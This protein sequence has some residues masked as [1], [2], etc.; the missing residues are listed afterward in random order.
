MS[1]LFGTDGVRGIA[2]KELTPELA[3]ALGRAGAFV[4]A[5]N[6]HKPKFVIGKDTRISG[7]LLESALIAGILSIGGEVIRA[8][9]IPTPAIAV[10]NRLLRAD[11]GVMISASHNPAE[12]NGIKFFDGQGF[13]LKDE[14]EDQ[15]EML[16]RSKFVYPEMTGDQVGFITEL[17]DANEMYEQFLLKT[18]H[19]DLTGLEIV[20]DCAN[21]AA[22]RIGPEVFEKAGAKVTV[23]GN[24]PDG[25]NINLNCGST[26][27]ERLKA[28][29]L[30]QKAHFGL[31]FDGDAD[32]M[33]AVDEN[34]NL[35]DGDKLLTIFACNMKKHNLLKNNTVVVTVM[36]NMGL[37]IALEENQCHS[38]K[39]QV[40][41]RYVL[42]EM[43]KNGYN[44]GGEQSGHLIL[45]D[46]N[47][48]GD[49]VLSGLQL[50]AI[51]KEEGKTLGTL[52]STMKIM[53]QV[54]VNAKVNGQ[55][56][57]DYE[58]DAAI[59][60]EIKRMEN[61][62]HKKGRVLIR[63]SGTEPL[64]RVMLEGENLEEIH[65]M[66]NRLAEMIATKLK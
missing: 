55:K 40:G 37:D 30:E 15:I 41:D 56:K 43:L 17:P 48:T 11:A 23:I 26:H 46:Y 2:N 51:V 49:G 10:L 65:D 35:V 52:A 54:L 9:V 57:M 12:F 24:D 8:G 28:E 47:T 32:R 66:A 58:K 34:G 4:L 18:L 33:L 29:V 22:Y 45:L 39:T 38:V 21:G 13:K 36:S 25:I 19:A 14:I 61:M 62:L 6:N 3:F 42:E 53:P 1:R 16:I 64:V 31:A 7:D 60:E 20:L 63:P 44:L 5:Q 50:A 59:Q 27:M